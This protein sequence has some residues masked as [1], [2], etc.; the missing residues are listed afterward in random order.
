MFF[1]NY[2]KIF[3]FLFPKYTWRKN[4]EFIYLTFDD[5]PVP[6]ATDVVLDILKEYGVK[7]TFF[8]VGDNINKHP[9]LF[10]RIIAEGHGVANH[11]YS[12]IRGVDTDNNTYYS[13]IEK[14]DLEIKK[15]GVVTSLLRPPHGRMKVS[16]RNLL[17]KKYEIIM[18]TVLSGDFSPNV[19]AEGCLQNTLKHTE[20]GSIILFHDSLKMIEKVKKV[21][22]QYLES[23]LKRGQSFKI[24]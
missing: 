15:Y 20:N 21:L 22:P 10:K 17:S 11:S 18:W 23:I 9:L 8:C 4:D 24:L 16:Q 2:N 6:G 14:C 13:D 1:Y 3:D 7:A 19:S 5:G 12:H